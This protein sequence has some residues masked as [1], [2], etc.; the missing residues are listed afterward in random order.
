MELGAVRIG[1]T[2]TMVLAAVVFA[3]PGAGAHEVADLRVT[4]DGPTGVRAGEKF[5]YVLA[6]HNDG[7]GDAR[8]AVLTHTPD[9]RSRFAGTDQPPDVCQFDGRELTCRL[10]TLTPDATRIIRVTVETAQ[11]LADGTR[12][13]SHAK[14]DS[15][16]YDDNLGNNGSS[17]PVMV[18]G[19]VDLAVTMDGPAEFVP[20]KSAAYAITVVNTGG[21]EAVRLRLRIAV[22]PVLT[23][24]SVPAGCTAELVCVRKTLAPGE[25]WSF[26]LPVEVNPSAQPG[27]VVWTTAT[28]TSA[29]E[30]V[31]HSDDDA[32]A[33]G[34]VGQALADLGVTVSGPR[35]LVPGRAYEYRA[36][37]RNHGPASARS[38]ELAAELA[39]LVVPEGYPD[40]CTAEGRRLR[41]E[42]GRLRPG[43]AVR[44]VFGVRATPDAVAGADVVTRLEVGSLT[45]DPDPSNDAASTSGTVPNARL[46]LRA[47][48]DDTEPRVGAVL[49]FA[50][51]LRNR[52]DSGTATGVVVTDRLPEGTSPLSAESD[53]GTVRPSPPRSRTMRWTIGELRTGRSAMLVLRARVRPD[54]PPG[55]PLVNRVRVSHGPATSVEV[56]GERCGGGAAC[57]STAPVIAGS[58]PSAASPRRPPPPEPEPAPPPSAPTPRPEPAETAEMVTQPP[59]SPLPAPGGVSTFVFG[60]SVVSMLVAVRLLVR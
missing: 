50:V 9:A 21:T 24:G 25:R 36:V 58:P 14:V 37:V 47:A 41:C 31:D 10:G 29:S 55:V 43:R 1:L 38:A 52:P 32:E 33:V 7:P 51:S 23:A 56:E 16:T 8:D 6:I 39:E 17:H 54:A 28:V 53:L 12:L 4:L 57:A 49:T 27:D 30:D 2:V 42:L 13:D 5:G 35:E 46:V 26:V 20:G 11:T 15:T 3:A 45:D 59:S 22:D 40:T 44:M 60:V 48:V 19:G 18:E 34:E